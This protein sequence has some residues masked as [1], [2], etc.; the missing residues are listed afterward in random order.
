MRSLSQHKLLV[1]LGVIMA[2]GFAWYF[3]L[4]SSP[5]PASPL[6]ATP[7]NGANASDK[8]IVATLLTLHAVTL[9]GT[10]FSNPVFVSLKDFSTAIVPEPVGR[11]DPFAPFSRENAA[12]A[13]S[14]RSTQIFI[15]KGSR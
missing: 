8:N 11:P 1:I 7:V 15:Q 10:I 9:D 14:T 5:A 2:A 12:S 6:S 4:G 3:L 13:T